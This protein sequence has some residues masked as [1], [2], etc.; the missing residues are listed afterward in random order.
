MPVPNHVGQ[1]SGCSDKV[2]WDDLKRF[3]LS[4]QSGQKKAVLQGHLGSGLGQSTSSTRGSHSEVAEQLRGQVVANPRGDADHLMESH[5][6]SA[7]HL[8]PQ[9]RDA[10]CALSTLQM[11]S[12]NWEG[13]TTLAPRTTPSISRPSPSLLSTITCP[14]LRSRL[15]FVQTRLN[16]SIDTMIFHLLSGRVQA[17]A[18]NSV[19]AG[20]SSR[21]RSDTITRRQKRTAPLYFTTPAFARAQGKNM[22]ESPSRHQ[23]AWLPTIPSFSWTSAEHWSPQ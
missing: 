10:V 6:N 21:K 22:W 12:S 8:T 3:R 15:A 20:R 2:V 17:A 16:S 4:R 5:N 14:P 7:D 1:P 18:N 9:L 23:Q 19:N 11:L 13:P